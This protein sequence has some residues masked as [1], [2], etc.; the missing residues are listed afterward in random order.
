MT[1]M[2]STPEI[3]GSFTMDGLTAETHQVPSEDDLRSEIRGIVAGVRDPVFGQDI[4]DDDSWEA[5][6]R[7][8]DYDTEGD[9]LDDALVM[10]VAD[11]IA[12]GRASS[13]DAPRAGK[14]VPVSPGKVT[15]GV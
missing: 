11:A 1:D 5:A 15:K 10:L 3:K 2:D 4:P 6:A 7:A 14:P 13:A 9:T 8:L 12:F